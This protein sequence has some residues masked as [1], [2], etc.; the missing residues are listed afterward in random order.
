[1]KDY[2]ALFSVVE[3][4]LCVR[5]NDCAMTGHYVQLPFKKSLRFSIKKKKGKKIWV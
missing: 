1:M 5:N 4:A 3:E 2:Q